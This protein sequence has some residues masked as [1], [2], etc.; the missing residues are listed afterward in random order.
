MLEEMLGMSPL[1]ATHGQLFAAG[2]GSSSGSASPIESAEGAINPREL[3]DEQIAEMMLNPL[4]WLWIVVFQHDITRYNGDLT[5]LANT[6]DKI[7]HSTKFQ[8]V[9]PLKLTEEYSLILRPVI[10]YISINGPAS[11]GI[12]GGTPTPEPPEIN[13]LAPG[14]TSAT[15]FNRQNG[16]GDTVLLANISN[17]T[18][19]PFIFG[20]G[21][22]FMFPTATDDRLGTEKWSVGPSVLALSISEKWVFGTI[23]QHWWSFAGESDRSHVSLTDVQPIVSYRITE[24]TKIG[25]APNIQYN[26]DTEQWTIPVGGGMSTLIRMGKVPLN[27]SLDY[28]HYVEQDDAFGQDWGLRLGLSTVVPQPAWARTPLFK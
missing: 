21:P 4:G 17:Q 13:P 6:G 5:D 14:G 10:Q 2:G 23:A 15:N 18:K 28:Y 9:M 27:L 12:T 25:F 26:W 7:M 16:L 11:F 24:T 19:P 8:P 20:Y 1:P 3:S 22:S